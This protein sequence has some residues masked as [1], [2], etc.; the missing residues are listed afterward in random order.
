VL[1]RLTG[2]AD[3][4]ALLAADY[5]TKAAVLV[6]QLDRLAAT[7]AGNSAPRSDVGPFRFVLDATLRAR[8]IKVGLSHLLSD[9]PFDLIYIEI[10]LDLEHLGLL[11]EMPE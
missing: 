9:R 8:H 6:L 7:D 1:V 2:F 11:A 5:S 4:V 3:V 10:D